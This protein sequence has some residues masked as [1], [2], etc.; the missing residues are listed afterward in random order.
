MFSFFIKNWKEILFIWAQYV[1]TCM[2]ASANVYKR[3][4][5]DPFELELTGPCHLPD[6]GAGNGT[7]V[8]SSF[9]G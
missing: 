6:V 4:V 7:L 5:S 1:Y 2:C 9:K 8:F 3:G